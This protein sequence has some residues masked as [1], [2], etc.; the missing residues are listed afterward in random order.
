MD[1]YR[2]NYA[3]LHWEETLRTNDS[4]NK[5]IDNAF[6]ETEPADE[7]TRKDIKDINKDEEKDESSE[8]AEAMLYG[9]NHYYHRHYYHRDHHHDHHHGHHHGREWTDIPSRHKPAAK[10]TK[11]WRIYVGI[12]H[13]ENLSDI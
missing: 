7:G 12:I 1:E 4:R 13:A 2:S 8:L 11:T 9:D 10:M 5:M 3:L 6:T